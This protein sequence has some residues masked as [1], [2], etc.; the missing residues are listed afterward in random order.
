MWV[1][2][3]EYSTLGLSDPLNLELQ[4][5]MSLPDLG[6]GTKLGSS[7]I[8]VCPLNQWAISPALNYFLI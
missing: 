5:I 2:T 7:T 1:C 3:Y 4:V 6:A 8:P